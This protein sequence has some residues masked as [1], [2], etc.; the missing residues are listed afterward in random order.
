MHAIC[1]V[2]YVLITSS[3]D[4]LCS[5]QSLCG[6]AVNSKQREFASASE[7]ASEKVLALWGLKILTVRL[8][9]CQFI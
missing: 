6:R 1:V 2:Y 9:L 5:P 7:L 4:D 8:Y 3:L